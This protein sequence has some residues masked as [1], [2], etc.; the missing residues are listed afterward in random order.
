MCEVKAD[1]ATTDELCAESVWA[2]AQFGSLLPSTG[3]RRGTERRDVTMI[4][5][6]RLV[7]VTLSLVATIAGTTLLSPPAANADNKRLNNSVVTNVYTIQHQAGRTT[8]IKRD[9]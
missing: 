8:E 5:P 4:H 7:A 2:T 9:P 3:P 1:F 6:L